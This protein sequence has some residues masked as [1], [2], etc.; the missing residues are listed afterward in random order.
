VYAQ[1]PHYPDAHSSVVKTIVALLQKILQP[2][3]DPSEAKKPKPKIVCFVKH[4]T[5]ADAIARG[6]DFAKLKLPGGKIGKIG[7]VRLDGDV[8]PRDRQQL[9]NKFANDPS[10]SVILATFGG[11]LVPRSLFFFLLVH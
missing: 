9:L 4:A 1:D 6:L 2:A 7:Y 10:I 5:A 8:P 11:T 3:A